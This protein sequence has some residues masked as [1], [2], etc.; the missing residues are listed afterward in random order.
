MSNGVLD[1]LNLATARFILYV[2]ICSQLFVSVVNV[3]VEE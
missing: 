3:A 2:V 1:N